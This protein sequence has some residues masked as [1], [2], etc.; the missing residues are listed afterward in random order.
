MQSPLKPIDLRAILEYV[1]MYRG[2]TFVI[3]IDGSVVDCDNFANLITD[4]AVLYNLGIK[5]VI[6]HGIAM[7]LRQICQAKGI[8]PSD[9]Y[10]IKPV[11]EETLKI[12][13]QVSA[14]LAE[15]IKNALTIQD[16]KCVISNALRSTEIGTLAGVDYL[17]AGKP[18][19]VDFATLKNFL[20]MGLIPIISPIALD[21][22]SRMLRMNSDVLSSELAV[23]LN[24]S[25]LIYVGATNALENEEEQAVAIEL[26]SLQ[27]IIKE[28]AGEIDERLLSKLKYASQ[29]LAS[30]KTNRAHILNGMSYDCL[31][32]EV[33]DTVGCGTMIYADEYQKIRRATISDA[34][35]IY[36]ISKISS[37]EENLVERSLEEIE[38]NIDFYYV[39]EIDASI[40][41]FVCLLDIG[42]N[43]AELASLHVQ[44]FYR[45]KSVARTL[46]EF[47][48]KKAKQKGYSKLF[49]LSTR[50]AEF[51]RICKFKEVSPDNLSAKR[52]EK[53][54][55]SKRNSKVLLLDLA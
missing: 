54:N 24:A 32:T 41:A 40:I 13:T 15:K 21:R 52:L 20:D 23:G 45:G 46:V 2:Q 14:C 10:G 16:L 44:Q 38:A 11:D 7:Q 17:N 51:F 50:S 53:Y 3:A 37:K 35:S 42:D 22:Q 34:I 9:I 25:K 36:N 47:I 39:Y 19:R 6:V 33:F 8:E 29:A 18:D 43:S 31:L 5:I 30:T 49:A 4:I 26:N 48:I 27:A 28:R 12:A 55:A 1:P